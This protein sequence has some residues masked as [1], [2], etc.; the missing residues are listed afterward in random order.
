MLLLWVKH[1]LYLYEGKVLTLVY[2]VLIIT[3]IKGELFELIMLGDVKES[4]LYNQSQIKL[5]YIT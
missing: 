1:F 5:V 2:F 3:I 4:N